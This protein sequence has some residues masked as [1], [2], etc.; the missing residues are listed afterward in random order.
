M[1]IAELL[2]K[3]NT[4]TTKTATELTEADRTAICRCVQCKAR[5]FPVMPP[6]PTKRKYHFRSNCH[7]PGC[8]LAE[9]GKTF[10]ITEGY[11]I[12]YHDAINHKD[13]PLLPI[14][15]PSP[16]PGTNPKSGPSEQEDER[17]DNYTVYEQK[18]V[19]AC[20]TIYKAICDMRLT[21]YIEEGL[22][23]KDFIVDKRT[24]E[25]VRTE[26]IGD[27]KMIVCRRCAVNQ[28][29]PPIPRRKGYVILRDA[30]THDDAQSIYIYA[31]MQESTHDQQ[32]RDKLFGNREKGIKRDPHKVIVLL[33]SFNPIPNEYYSLYEISPLSS[34]RIAF[35]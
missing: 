21:D 25:T 12:K 8:G 10:K 32:F 5:A 19:H 28:I 6:D 34:A 29:F 7:V 11:E 15:P 3:E 33:V 14:V 35:K 22:Q 31:K 1:D 27:R 26:G 24:I 9:G 30:F 16:R 13:K 4:W 23:V 17:E 18:M 2:T 20:G